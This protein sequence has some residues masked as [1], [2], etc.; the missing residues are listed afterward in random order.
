MKTV[1]RP[2]AALTLL[3]AV[4]V[5]AE[6][7]PANATHE[8][9]TR[10]VRYGPFTIPAA[11]GMMNM[12]HID[13]ALRLWVQ[14]PCSGCYVTSMTPNLTYADGS[15]AGVNTGAM[16]HHMV[17]ASQ[18]RS[19]PTCS[20]NLLGLVGER[21]F[22]SGDERTRIE[23]PNGYGYRVG[24]FDQWNL[25]ADLMNMMP[26]EQTVYLDVTFTYRSG[27]ANLKPVKPVW[28]DVDQCGDSEYTVPAGESDTHWDWNVNVPGRV[29]AIGGHVHTEGHGVRIEATNETTGA[30]I[31]NSVATYGGSPE[32]IDMM[33][34]PWI[35]DMSRCIADPVA[36]VAAGDTV[37]VH[38]VYNAPVE[39]E[40]AMGIMIAYIHQS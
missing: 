33:G 39:T 18:F 28:L 30:S 20:G 27:S 14:K 4:F 16:L 13:N 7:A 15:R 38:S 25:I 3:L 12:G 21:F 29:V 1:L 17:L 19:D 10:T 31:C 8:V 6:A 34:M 23:F 24:Y 2:V 5:V 40:G 36:T 22:A 9:T 35:S 11:S 32:Y 37:R 26:M